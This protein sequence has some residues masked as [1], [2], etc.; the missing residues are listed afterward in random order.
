MRQVA[1]DTENQ[2]ITAQGGTIWEDVDLAA[3]KYGMAT[4][5]GTVNHTGVGGLT[6]GGGYGWLT[7]KYGL[8]IDN[9]LGAEVVLADGR[10][11]KTSETENADLF[12]ALRGAGQSFGVV[13]SFT[14]RGYKQENPVWGGLLVFP[15]S[16]IEKVVDFANHLVATTEGQSGMVFGIGAPAPARKP[17]VLAVLFYN[18]T[19]EEALSY[20]KPLFDLQP[21]VNRTRQMP[22]EEVNAMLNMVSTH[23]DRK[24]QKGAAFTVPL[25]G[26]LAKQ[27]LD[28]YLKFITEIPDAIKTIVL[29]EF[30][31][32]RVVNKVSQTA[33]SFANRGEHYNILFSTRWVGEQNDI[34]CREWTRNAARKIVDSQDVERSGDGVGQYGNYDGEYRH[35]RLISSTLTDYMT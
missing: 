10:I 24:T 19:T 15:T 21:I 22:Y 27:V 33:M 8:T 34:A 29:F 35:T 26:K 25:S 32:Q 7:G 23:G 14:F 9:L 11:L 5:G 1:I 12:W 13:T 18:G 30:F 17:A 31:S 3:A 16:M 6:L 4:V 2:T 28:D 20:Y